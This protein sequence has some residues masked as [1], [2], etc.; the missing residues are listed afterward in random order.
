MPNFDGR[1]DLIH[2]RGGYRDSPDSSSRVIISVSSENK[3]RHPSWF[4]EVALFLEAWKQ[5]GLVSK[6]Q[7][8]V[9][10]G[11]GRMG[12]YDTCDYALLLLSY[13]VSHEATLETFYTNLDPI[14]EVL[15]ALWQR[16]TLPSRSALS[17]FLQ[18][19][20]QEHVESLRRLLFAEFLEKGLKGDQMGGLYDRQGQRHLLFDVDMTKQAA[21]QRALVEDELRPLPRRRMSH[22]C[23]PG[24]RGRKRGELVRSRTVLQQGHTHEWL[25]PRP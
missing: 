12:D 22:S 10:V 24:Y 25:G 1:Q 5:S 23:A 6:L 2:M 8:E 4:S 14:K 15:A 3:E 17:R 21:R 7:E 9:R 11:R 18:D 19:V 13:A 16:Q 20:K